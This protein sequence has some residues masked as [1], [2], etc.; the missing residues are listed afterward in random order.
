MFF[1]IRF[2]D[3]TKTGSAAWAADIKKSP[4]R[5]VPDRRKISLFSLCNV[6]Y[7]NVYK[8]LYVLPSLY[9]DVKKEG[10]P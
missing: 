3:Q 8:Y 1:I 2:K 6:V 7:S 4:A 9:I 5:S 10:Y